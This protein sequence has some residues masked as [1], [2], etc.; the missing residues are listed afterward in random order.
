MPE[1]ERYCRRIATVD[2]AIGVHVGAEVGGIR[3][4]TGTVPGLQRVSGIDEAIAIRVANEDCHE[5]TT[6]PVS[7]P[8]LTPPSVM[9]LVCPL[10]MPVRFIVM[11]LVPLPVEEETLPA[12]KLTETPV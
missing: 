12:P 6:S 8:S 1:R 2:E 3:R 11:L 10:V 9:V 5:E 7:T 4:L